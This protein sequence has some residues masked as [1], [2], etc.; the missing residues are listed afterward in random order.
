MSAKSIA[1]GIA[2]AEAGPLIMVAGVAIVVLYVLPK[3]IRGIF[4]NKNPLTNNQTDA[5]G[6]PVTAY[7]ET[8]TP[9]IGTLGAAANTVSG[10]T[11]AS[12][13]E[14]LGGKLADITMPYD[15]NSP[16]S[17]VNRTQVVTPNY[18]NDVSQLGGEWQ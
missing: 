18:V 3:V 5:D 13:G 12:I 11:L 4:T 16:S 1:A 14:W 8:T 17:G 7:S 10:G 6:N 2:K 15:P 9:V